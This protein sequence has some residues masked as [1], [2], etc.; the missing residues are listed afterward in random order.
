ML[1]QTIR[2]LEYRIISTHVLVSPYCGCG[3]LNWEY[4]CARKRAHVRF[5]DWLTEARGIIKLPNISTQRL[6]FVL[7]VNSIGPLTIRDSGRKTHGKDTV[8]HGQYYSMVIM[9]FYCLRI[10]ASFNL[11]APFRSF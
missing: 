2:V 5:S 3:R 4:I 9:T 8:E 1:K 11:T 6:S 10:A 7:N